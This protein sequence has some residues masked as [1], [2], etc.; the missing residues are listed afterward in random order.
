MMNMEIHW[1]SLLP[2]I[3]TVVAGLALTFFRTPAL[4][5]GI[6]LSALA[7][8]AM[9]AGID[10]VQSPQG[11]KR[12]LFHGVVTF[13]AY[14][15]FFTLLLIGCAALTL[16]AAWAY[17]PREKMAQSEVYALLMFSLTGM[18]ILPAATHLIAVFIAIEIMSIAIYALVGA[19]RLDVKGNESSLKY[20]LLGAFASGIILYGIALTYGAA[21]SVQFDALRDFAASPDHAK[22]PLFIA[23]I[24]MLLI[25]FGFKVAAAP[26]HAWTPDVYEGA[27][28][29]ITGFMSTAVK[30]ASFA[31][32]LR[33]LAV[34][35]LPVK[36]EWVEV[37]AGLAVITMFTGNILAFVQGNIK[38]M[39]AYSSIAHTGYMMMGLTALSNQEGAF[40][41]AAILYY[42]VAYCLTNLA[43]FAAIGFISKQGEKLVEIEDL[44]GLGSKF[45]GLS[46]VIAICM[47]SLIGIPPT[48]GFFGKYFLFSAVIQQG[49]AWLAVVGIINSILSVYYYL[50]VIVV[51][52]FKEPRADWSDT[53]GLVP[54]RIVGVICAVMII[55]AGVGATSLLYLV[56]GAQPLMAWARTSVASLF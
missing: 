7:L 55:W 21:G 44:S 9:A 4:L 39:L 36:G 35:F 24:A 34:A 17:F 26:F 2:I 15:H 31:F 41:G 30:A 13:D 10:L 20:F 12:V 38:R 27:P 33:T 25:G 16:V 53:T 22:L 32:I 42:L 52:Y 18:L 19:R 3:I 46:L 50:R 37:V 51:M 1:L 11:F 45:P 5:G 28:A 40:A 23:G 56:P 54:V 47:A 49:Y 14:S 8:A 6:S 48:A 43:L 29:P